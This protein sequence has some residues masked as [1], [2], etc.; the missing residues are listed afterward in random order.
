MIL[1]LN[2]ILNARPSLQN[3]IEQKLPSRTA[4]KLYKIVERLN[5]ELESFEKAQKDL[6]ARYGEEKDGVVTIEKDNQD[7][8]GKEMAEL[9]ATE[10]ELEIQPIKLDELTVEL[11]ASEVMAVAFLI[12][13]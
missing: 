8:F 5:R 1:T 4:F 13:E 6:F 11:S 10:V 2:T 9:L 12:E 7:A 3:L